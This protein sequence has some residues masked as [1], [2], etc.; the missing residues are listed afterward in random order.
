PPRPRLGARAAGAW[1]VETDHLAQLAFD[2]SPDLS[3]GVAGRFAG[4]TVSVPLDRRDLGIVRAVVESGRLV[5]VAA[6]LSTDAGSGY[7]LL[8]FGADRS[9]AVPIVARDGNL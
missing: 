2:A 9:V 5:S 1:R 3:P 6:D 4:A 8:A 7:W